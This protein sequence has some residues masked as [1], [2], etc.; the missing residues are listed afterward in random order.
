MVEIKSERG[1]C[2]TLVRLRP[3]Y[4]GARYTTSFS[5][6]FKSRISTQLFGNEAPTGAIS[7]KP[8]FIGNGQVSIRVIIGTA[9]GYYVDNRWLS[10]DREGEGG[11]EIHGGLAA[12][13]RETRV[14]SFCP[15]L[16]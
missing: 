7:D 16:W 13:T 9:E 2:C 12:A 11:I 4:A 15:M 1:L 6:N 10:T 5:D 14:W 3:L 8:A